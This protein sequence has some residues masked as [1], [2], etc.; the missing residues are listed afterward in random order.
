L[1]ERARFGWCLVQDKGGIS[2]HYKKKQK[3]LK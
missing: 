1:V 3:Y 2:E